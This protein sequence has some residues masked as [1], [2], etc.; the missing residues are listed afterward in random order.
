MFSFVLL[1][2]S[3]SLGSSMSSPDQGLAKP[4]SSPLSTDTPSGTNSSR[5]AFH[6][7]VPPSPQYGTSPSVPNIPP[8]VLTPSSTKGRAVSTSAKL[9]R[10]D[11]GDRP[12]PKASNEDLIGPKTSPVPQ[13]STSALTAQLGS[14]PRLESSQPSR[15]SSRPNLK[16]SGR[17][18]LKG[19]DSSSSNLAEITNA[20][21]AKVLRRHL[22][23]AEERRPSSSTPPSDVPTPSDNVF[24][25]GDHGDSGLQGVP[26]GGPSSPERNASEQ[27]PIPFDALGGDVT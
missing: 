23:S 4:M 14:S 19:N 7:G 27:F 26:S 18:L 2:I 17:P 16:E 5:S 11:K 12:K 20:E 6:P 8:R 24:P 10:E 13:A 21:K 1:M 9:N 3:I 15:K 25:V 22:V